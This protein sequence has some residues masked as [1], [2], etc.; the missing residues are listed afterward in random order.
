[1][2]RGLLPAALGAV[3]AVGAVA[4]GAVV[5]PYP[6]DLPAAETRLAAIGSRT[7]PTTFGDVEYLERGEGEPVLVVHG[8]LHGCDGGLLSVRDTVADRRVIAPS[9]FG[10]LRSALPTAATP[11]DQAAAFVELLDHLG[12]GAVDVVAISAGT[13]PGV[14]LALGHPERVR[15]LTV[16]SG[17]W[18]GSPTARRPPDWARAMYADPPMW[19]LRAVAPAALARLMGVPPGFPRDEAEAAYV[20]EMVATIFPVRPR[21]A[22]AL[23]DA[24]VSDPA[25]EASTLEAL[26]V[27][28]LVVHMVD[29]PLA[30]F[31][32]A[33]QAASRIPGARFVAVPSGGHLAVGQTGRVRDEV[34]AFLDALPEPGRGSAHGTSRHGPAPA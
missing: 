2:R 3:A 11:D 30:S 31:D 16:V 28:V 8:I 12:L 21:A 29:D 4:A 1:M 24:Y 19:A 23:F 27:P 32:A 13:T 20:D 14:E 15:S 9:R 10:Y 17:S 33:A 7:V 6:R 22:G 18:P 34:T 26:A 25:V 5:R